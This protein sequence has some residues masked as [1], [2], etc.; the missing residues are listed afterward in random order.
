MEAVLLGSDEYFLRRGDGN[1]SG[2][3]VAV[4]YDVLGVA[5]DATVLSTAPLLAAGVPRS[6]LAA[7]ILG[8]PEATTDEV[9]GLFLQY[10]HRPADA[11][12]LATYTSDVLAGVPDELILMLVLGSHDH[13][14][15]AQ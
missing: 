15:Q 12:V 14:Q 13:Y 5:P 4:S 9:E 8:S 3:L 6:E 1:D 10:L 7:A 2:W 11:D